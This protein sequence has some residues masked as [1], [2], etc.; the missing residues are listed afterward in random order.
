MYWCSNLYYGSNAALNKKDILK[1]L[2]HKKWAMGIYIITLS[3]NDKNLLD[4]YDTIQF[5]QSKFRHNKL[6]A[7][8]IAIGKDEAY[9]LVAAIIDDVYKNTGSFNV[10]AY[11]SGKFNK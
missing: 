7:V 2:K 1:S 11:F 4:I 10:K 5:K 6:K 3:D 8:G 9:E